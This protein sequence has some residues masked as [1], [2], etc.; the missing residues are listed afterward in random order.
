MLFTPGQNRLI[1]RENRNSLEATRSMLFAMN[2]PTTLWG[3][4]VDIA[5]PA[6]NRAIGKTAGGI[7]PFGRYIGRKPKSNHLRDFASLIL[8]KF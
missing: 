2:L 7:T 1:E 3:E 4:A 5:V 8:I 6:L